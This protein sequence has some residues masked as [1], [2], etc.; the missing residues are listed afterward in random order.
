MVEHL[1]ECDLTGVIEDYAAQYHFWGQHMGVME[2]YKKNNWKRNQIIKGAGAMQMYIA[3]KQQ[4]RKSISCV[5][6]GLIR[7]QIT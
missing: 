2:G 7:T 3:S 6:N 1:W 5:G 4:I